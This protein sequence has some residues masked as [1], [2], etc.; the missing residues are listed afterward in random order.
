[1]NQV[2]DLCLFSKI[3]SFI[4]VLAYEKLCKYFDVFLLSSVTC[5]KISEQVL[6]LNYSYK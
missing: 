3:I 4:L 6:V 5:S 2:M 1:M